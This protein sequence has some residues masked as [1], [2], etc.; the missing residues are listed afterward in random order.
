MAGWAQTMTLATCFEEVAGKAAHA[1]ET[2]RNQRGT[3]PPPEGSKEMWFTNEMTTEPGDYSGWGGGDLN[4][5]TNISYSG[6][7]NVSGW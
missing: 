3:S 4:S 5:D 7:E 2:Y 1:Y 6:S